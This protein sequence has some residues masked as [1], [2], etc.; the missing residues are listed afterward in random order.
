MI[1]MIQYKKTFDGTRIDSKIIGK[2]IVKF[3]IL[4]RNRNRKRLCGDKGEKCDFVKDK[5]DDEHEIYMQIKTELLDDEN[6]KITTKIKKEPQEP[7]QSSNIT[8]C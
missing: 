3:Q 6:K 4:K 7:R 5:E 8:I 1:E 2:W